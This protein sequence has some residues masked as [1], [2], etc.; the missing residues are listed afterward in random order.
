[1]PVKFPRLLSALLDGI[2]SR[3]D[4]EQLAAHCL[5]SQLFEDLPRMKYRKPKRTFLP[6]W[7][8]SQERL[9]GGP[10]TASA[11]CLSTRVAA[12]Q[13]QVFLGSISPRER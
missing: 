12:H 3:H 13:S 8:P 2:R 6:N 4:R 11:V 7:R 9:V 5:H 1:M 10:C